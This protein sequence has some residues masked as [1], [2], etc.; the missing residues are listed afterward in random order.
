MSHSEVYERYPKL[1]S[2]LSRMDSNTL[3]GFIDA[4]WASDCE[5]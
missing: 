3:E 5:K 4:D 2:L 1:Q